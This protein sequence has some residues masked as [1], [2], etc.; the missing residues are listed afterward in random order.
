MLI[1]ATTAYCL[2]GAPQRQIADNKRR[3]RAQFN[4]LLK[5][6]FTAIEG[7]SDGISLFIFY[8]HYHLSRIAA[9]YHWLPSPR[10]FR[11]G[12]MLIMAA[13][14]LLSRN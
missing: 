1:A 4:S 12:R 8:G 11:L 7:Y 2:L 9:I 6:L 13:D 3:A 5:L 10:R 14:Y